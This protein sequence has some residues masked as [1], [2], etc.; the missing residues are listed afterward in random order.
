MI[1]RRVWRWKY[2][3]CQI[4]FRF[5]GHKYIWIFI[6]QRK[7]TFAP[8]LNADWDYTRYLGLLAGNQTERGNEF[9]QS[10]V[11]L[12]IFSGS[13]WL[14]KLNSYLLSKF[15]KYSAQPCSVIIFWLMIM[16]QV[17][18]WKYSLTTFGHKTIQQ[19]FPWN[20]IN[21]LKKNYNR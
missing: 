18:S 6:L 14:F 9:E 16:R 7:I 12:H 3:F 10:L 15:S 11:A 19:N 17:L 21:V 1:M 13:L 4:F 8:H 2:S 5:W 20:I